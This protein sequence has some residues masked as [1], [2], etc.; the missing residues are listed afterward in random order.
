M[1]ELYINNT[2]IGA[3]Y[4]EELYEYDVE[5]FY[6]GVANPAKNYENYYF[7][8]FINEF[9]VFD[10]RICVFA[11]AVVLITFTKGVLIVEACKT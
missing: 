5:D 7:K 11:V 2:Y 6:I 10:K 3:E 4:V 9:A 1:I 8:G